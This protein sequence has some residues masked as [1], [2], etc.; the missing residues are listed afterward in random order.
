MKTICGIDCTGCGWKEICKGC[1]ETNGHPFGGECVA[2]ECYKSGGENCYL[3]YKNRLIEDFNALGIIDMPT[4][5]NLCQL[6]GAYV[7][8][9][10]LFPVGKK[11]D[12]WMTRK[13]ISV[14][15]LK[16]K[17]ATDVTDLLQIIIFCLSANMVVMV[18][19]LKSLYTKRDN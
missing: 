17:T 18:R 15:S 5:T 3:T 1:T 13:Y 6:N 7:N 2:A 12:Y 19:I 4:V 14:I 9:N 16:K 8:W 11:S 10:I